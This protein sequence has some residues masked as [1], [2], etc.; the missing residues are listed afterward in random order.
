[1]PGI[2]L[3]LPEDLAN[4]LSDLAKTNGQSV[5]YLVMDV[6]SDYIEHKRALTAQIERAVEEADPG[7]LGTDDQVAAMRAW[8]RG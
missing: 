6:L 5:S 4:S 3:D 8:R 1:M 2:S 7:K